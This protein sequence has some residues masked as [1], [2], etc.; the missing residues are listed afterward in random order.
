MLITEIKGIGEKNQKLLNKLGIY[1]VEDLI[2]YYPRTYDTYE[3]PVLVG[4][5]EEPGT[6]AVYGEVSGP[7]SLV[8]RGRLQIV[9]VLI[10]D[11]H[12]DGIKVTWF[13]MP[14]LKTTLKRGAR[15]VF[16]GRIIF[17]QGCYTMEQP[18]MYS[19]GDYEQKL[20]RMEP[21][22]H[23][24]AG[25]SNNLMVKTV[26]RA[27][28]MV[29]LEHEYLPFEI[30]RE[31]KLMDHTEALRKIHFPVNKEEYIL[32]RKRIVFEEFF[33]FILALRQL[34][35]DNTI[36][37]NQ[38]KIPNDPRTDAFAA[39]LPYSLTNA[40][41][42]VW[43]EIQRDMSGERLMNRLIQGDVGS[44]KTIVAVLALMNTVY[45]GY[46]GAM[47]VPTEV[48]AKQQYESTCRMFK[49][50]GVDIHVGLLIG[51][52]TPKEKKETYEKLREGEIQI[53]IGT[54]AIIQA[55][56][57]YKNLAL[58]ITD[59][60]HRFGV[61]QRKALSDKGERPNVIVMSATP[62][63]RT[64]AIILYGDLDISVINE[65]P[66]NRLPIKNCVVDESYRP[67]AYRFIDKQVQTGRQAY[68]I[69]PMVEDSDGMEVENVTDYSQELSRVFPQYKIGCLHGKMKAEAKNQ[70][71]EEFA[72]N[73]VQILVSTTVVEV[74]V[75]VPNATVMMIENAERFGLAQLHQLRG[76]V[77][78]GEYQSYCIMMSG[79]KKEENKKRL[80]IMNQSND[81]FY[82]A[83]EDL[84]SRGP[85]DLFGLRQ[86]GDLDF[87]LGD[88]FQD[89]TELQCASECAKKYMAGEYGVTDKEKK[90]ID[91]KVR[92]YTEKCWN[93][94][95]I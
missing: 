48:L 68:V 60:Q 43:E 62:I 18:V 21:I 12:G 67:N 24:T 16:R 90:V 84:K 36:A 29:D 74:G 49:E 23:L 11:Y 30:R 76:R 92:E 91:Q 26:A 80:E 81:G 15:F 28:E 14:Y 85:G 66:S 72:R 87:G 46:Q 75:N 51:S 64:L 52:M 39:S 77:G 20:C 88:I 40:Q 93:R 79:S 70:V 1:E 63:P 38:Y 57:V 5:I 44:G 89:A 82:I 34:K 56:T 41:Q 65:L 45:A 71:M 83:S 69:C 61:N 94:I 6:Y 50:H 4:E 17:K 42:K 35:K 22:Y 55:K 27:M 8:K 33:L 31:F 95:N 78:R 37:V 25:L 54:N 58:V 32:A 13:N 10:K 86:S 53:L 47:M 7:V 19:P 73:E 3:E 59:E 2:S 9:S